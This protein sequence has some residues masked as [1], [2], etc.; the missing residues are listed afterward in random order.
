[1]AFYTSSQA[2]YN[3]DWVEA[4]LNEIPIK[5]KRE[6]FNLKGPVKQY[7]KAGNFY[8]D[9]EGFLIYG[10]FGSNFEFTYNKNYKLLSTSSWLGTAFKPLYPLVLDANGR[11]IEK[12]VFN[13]S[14]I[15]TYDANGNW[16][17]TI[18]QYGTRKENSYIYTYDTKNRVVK[19]EYWYEKI[20]WEQTYTYAKDGDFLVVT[21]T[22]TDFRDASKNYKDVVYYKKGNWYGWVKNDNVKYDRFGNMISG[23]DKDGKEN[24]MSTYK[25]IYYG[26]AGVSDELEGRVS[27]KSKPAVKADPN[28]IQ[29]NCKDGFG[30]YKYDNGTYVG[31]FEYGN[32]HGFGIY[33][34]SSGDTY[35]GMWEYNLAQGYGAYQAKAGDYMSGE[36][37]KELL[38][39]Y[40]IKMFGN[41]SA[42]YGFY[43]DG[44]L[45]TKYN[46]YANNK[47]KGCFAGE[48]YNGYGQ[49]IYDNGGKFIGFY[50]NGYMHQGVWYSPNGDAYT[51]QFGPNNTFEGYGNYTYKN[52][53]SYS[54][55]YKNSKREGKGVMYYAATKIIKAGEWK[56]DVL[57]K[58]YEF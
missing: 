21:K 48:C 15:Y 3:I 18:D 57:I 36:F 33:T 1:F 45:V 43:K 11:I 29:G 40:A 19:A 24:S 55:Q 4:P 5:Y 17:G 32:K 6:H 42:E 51:G 31:F 38:N 28:C 39:G 35:T 7:Q 34:W 49:Y 25:Y 47:V 14:E 12:K 10:D 44:K 46:Y 20:L 26:D 2:Q 41:N 30:S 16:T 22:N 9:K 27:E 52:K 54:G 8:F 53:D 50:K 37:K 58:E 23:V 13:N 56:D